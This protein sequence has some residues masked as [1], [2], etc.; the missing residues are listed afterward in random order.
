MD[1]IIL[2]KKEGKSLWVLFFGNQENPAQVNGKTFHKLDKGKSW[3]LVI[4]KRH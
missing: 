1:S 2:H 4:M 3:K